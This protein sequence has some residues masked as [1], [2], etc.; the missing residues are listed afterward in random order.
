LR[1]GHKKSAEASDVKICTSARETDQKVISAW[2][3]DQKKRKGLTDDDVTRLP[4]MSSKS[5]KGERERKSRAKFNKQL[6]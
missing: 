4:L 3:I 6:V 5:N 2:K 1:L